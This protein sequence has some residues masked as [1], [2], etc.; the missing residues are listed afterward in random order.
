WLMRMGVSTQLEQLGKE[1]DFRRRYVASMLPMILAG[2]MEHARA[3]MGNIQVC[4]SGGSLQI[5]AHRG[6]DRAFL[7]FFSGGRAR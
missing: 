1:E 2:A 5:C 3:E 6:F 7:E 4:G